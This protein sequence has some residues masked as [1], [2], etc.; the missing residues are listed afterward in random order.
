VTVTRTYNLSECGNKVA[1]NREVTFTIKASNVP[2]PFEVWWKVRNTG[3]E[4]IARN[5]TR[6]QIVK[7]GGSRS[8]TEPT[9]FRGSHSVEVYILKNGFVVAKDHHSVIIT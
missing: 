9:S 4:T 1:K 2:E 5:M 6:G 8:R 7:D 3:P